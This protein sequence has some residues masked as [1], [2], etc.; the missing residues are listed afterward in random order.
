MLHSVALT[1]RVLN[2]CPP[3][4]PSNSA[5]QEVS[6]GYVAGRRTHGPSEGSHTEMLSVQFELG[7]LP[8]RAVSPMCRQP[9]N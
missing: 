1:A 4:T 6:V 8:F 2:N 3:G 5:I 9:L 7:S